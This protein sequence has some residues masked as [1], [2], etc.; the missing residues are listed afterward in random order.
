MI[1]KIY[2][3]YEEYVK[4]FNQTLEYSNSTYN[5]DV[6]NSNDKTFRNISITI[7][8]NKYVI[9]SKSSNPIIHFIIKHPKLVDAINN[10][11]PIVKEE[12]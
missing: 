9:L 7:L 10:F 11:K 12:K 4:H 1:K 5:Y 2:Y 6:I 3:S 8:K